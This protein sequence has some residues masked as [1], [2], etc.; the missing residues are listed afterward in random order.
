[1]RGNYIDLISAYCDR[2]CERCPFTERC[3]AYAVEVAVAMCDGDVAA[4]IELAV[5]QPPPMDDAD[6]RRR[7]DLQECLSELDTASSTVMRAR[8]QIDDR[9]QRDA[10]P[11]LMARAA[12][13]AMSAGHWL[14]AHRARVAAS[15][16]PVLADALDV[17][18]WDRFF[19]P[20]K[21]GR[22][23][24]GRD[25]WLREEPDVDA[26]QSDWNG[27]AKVAL[28]SIVRSVEAWEAIAQSTGD[29]DARHVADALAV[30]RH[31]VESAFPDA[32]RFIR[33]GFD[34]EPSGSTGPHC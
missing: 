16:D 23:L 33:P 20:A 1:M 21:V 34:T 13:T 19:I 7:E 17:A 27:S 22:A 9:R 11:P 18:G 2:W 12:E 4:G 10:A 15:A 3:S 31:D 8:H 28:I 29:T 25:R 14:A 24:S 30:L 26:L 32:W 6:K 5:G